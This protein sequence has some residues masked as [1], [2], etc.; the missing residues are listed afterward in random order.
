MGRTFNFH[1]QVNYTENKNNAIVVNIIDR[2]QHEGTDKQGLEL[3]PCE[4]VP[5]EQP[6]PADEENTASQTAEKPTSPSSPKAILSGMELNAM[7]LLKLAGLLNKEYKFHTKEETAQNKKLRF[8]TNGKRALMAKTLGILF[9]T[10]DYLQRYCKDFWQMP[11]KKQTISDALSDLYKN[12]PD[13]AQAFQQELD[14]IL[15]PL[16][17]EAR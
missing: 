7:Q 9:G 1:G 12:H 2:Q 5:E 17:K 4:I 14:K 10:D 13:Q 3:T 16:N 6:Q 11:A 8:L 15:L